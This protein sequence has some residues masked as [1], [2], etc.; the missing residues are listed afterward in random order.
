MVLAK[1]DKQALVFHG[2]GFHQPNHYR[3]SEMIEI[4]KYF[5]ISLNILSTPKVGQLYKILTM[6]KSLKVNLRLLFSWTMI[7]LA[8]GLLIC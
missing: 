1:E 4:N 8:D 7:G 3:R 5:Y 2:G 6:K